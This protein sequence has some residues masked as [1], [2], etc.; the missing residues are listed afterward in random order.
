ME[1]H[2]VKQMIHVD[3]SD[4]DD[5]IA[6]LLDAGEEYITDAVGLYNDDDP[7]HRLL[8]VALVDDCYKRRSYTVEKTEKTAAVLRSICGQLRDG[9]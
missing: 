5:Y 4:D 3:Y 7:R 1:F 6:L 2:E 9:W 8:L